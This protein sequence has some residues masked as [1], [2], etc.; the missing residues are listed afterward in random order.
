MKI[1]VRNQDLLKQFVLQSFLVVLIPS[2]DYSIGLVFSDDHVEKV[3]TGVARKKQVSF[4][5]ADRSLYFCDFWNSGIRVVLL[6]KRL[7]HFL[8]PF[9]KVV[10]RDLELIESSWHGLILSSFVVY[11]KIVELIVLPFLLEYE[12]AALNVPSLQFVLQLPFED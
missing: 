5:Y 12:I 1:S 3:N 8:L 11:E 6:V 7:K 9:S 10:Q 2:R 4:V